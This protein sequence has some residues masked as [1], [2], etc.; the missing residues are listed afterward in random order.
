MQGALR[1][2]HIAQRTIDAKSHQRAAFKNFQVDVG[3]VFADALGK[4]GIDELDDGR[5]VLGFEKIGDLR[6]RLCELRKIGGVLDIAGDFL[7]SIVAAGIACRRCVS[8]REAGI[9]FDL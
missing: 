1:L 7:H 5:I 4:Q 3:C 6:Q 2:H 9:E 8:P